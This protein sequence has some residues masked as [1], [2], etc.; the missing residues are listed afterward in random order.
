[1]SEIVKA[2]TAIMGEVGTVKKGGHNEFQNYDYARA[3]D[4][5]HALQAVM[6]KH[7]V[8]AIQ[9]E[10]GPSNM[11]AGERGAVVQQTYRF[12]LLHNSGERL[13]EIEGVPFTHTGIAQ[14]T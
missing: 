1:M 13:T 7:G 12:F 2:L 10:N 4:V 11:V 8:L 5:A 14:A 3:E 9:T 6:G